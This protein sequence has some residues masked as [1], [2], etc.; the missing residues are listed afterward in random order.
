M[1]VFKV[2]FSNICRDFWFEISYNWWTM[3]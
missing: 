3:S 1:V 2:A